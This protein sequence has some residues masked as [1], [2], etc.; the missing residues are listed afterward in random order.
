VEGHGG[1]IWAESTP[2]E[3]ATVHFTIP[4]YRSRRPTA[5]LHDAAATATS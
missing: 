3:G 1:R 2:G 4:G 5:A